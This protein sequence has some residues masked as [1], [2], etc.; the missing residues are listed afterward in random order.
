MRSFALALASLILAGGAAHAQLPFTSSEMKVTES[1][2]RGP[3]LDV[4]LVGN[5]NS[6]R[7]L[8]EASEDCKGLLKSGAA[9]RFRNVGRWGEFSADDVS[10]SPVGSAGLAQWRDSRP[11]GR[12]GPQIRRQRSQFQVLGQDEEYTFVRG[13][14]PLAPMVG[15]TQSQDLVA[16]LP[17]EPSCERPVADGFAPME[18]RRRGQPLLLIAEGQQCA[19]TAF[20]IPIGL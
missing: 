1:V 17:R 11:R 7:W 16:F 2:Q 20:A 13:T 9:I 12:S 15:F 19:I 4:T 14:F 8:F 10:C 18:F 3:Y 6:G 5:R